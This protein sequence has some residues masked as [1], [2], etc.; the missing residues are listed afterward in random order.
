MILLKDFSSHVG[1]DAR[2]R[3]STF[4]RHDDADVNDNGTL[5]L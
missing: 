1:I 5:L 4:G 2:V 3:A